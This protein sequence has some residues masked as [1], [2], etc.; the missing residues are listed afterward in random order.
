M[1]LDYEKAYDRVNLNFLLEILRLRGF[2]QTWISWI[3]NIVLG[4]SVSVHA[5]G[6]ESS[7]FKTR[8]GLR[9]GI[10]SPS[11]LLFNL[12]G[13]VLTKMLLKAA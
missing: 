4:G 3:K 9:R 10:P 11:P 13:D 5:N 1:K 12:V 7:P 6:D 8:K 2:G